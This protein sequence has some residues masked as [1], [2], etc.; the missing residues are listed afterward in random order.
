MDGA[1]DMSD[2][3]PSHGVEDQDQRADAEHEGVPTPPVP[4]EA[5]GRG[6]DIDKGKKGTGSMVA[7]HK[8]E[9]S[10]RDGARAPMMVITSPQK[11]SR[12]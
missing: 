2:Q 9:T 4:D 3:D 10:N 5:W 6:F 8:A 1:T 12:A 7:N 11:P